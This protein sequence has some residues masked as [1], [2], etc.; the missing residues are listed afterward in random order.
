[1]TSPVIHAR[2]SVRRCG[3][4]YEEHM[5]LHQ[6]LDS[7]KVAFCDARHR[8]VYHHMEGVEYLASIFSES[9]ESRINMLAVGVQHLREDMGGRIATAEDWCNEIDVTLVPARVEHDVS[10]AKVAVVA[11]YGG[12]AADYTEIFNWLEYPKRW[13]S[14][15]LAGIFSHHSFG[16]F[17]AEELFGYETKLSSGKKVPTRYICET[18]ITRLYGRVPQL[19]EWCQAIRHRA[20]MNI[21]YIV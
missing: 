20:W 11:R 5:A 8:V 15:D 2:S 6:A 12:Q 4:N 21:G 18:W 7:S 3:G 19:A 14:E 10:E 9:E 16:C 1:M 13:A 17:G